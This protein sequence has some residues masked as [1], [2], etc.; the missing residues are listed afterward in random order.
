MSEE[1][2]EMSAYSFNSFFLFFF[3]LTQ[4]LYLENYFLPTP[5]TAA[6]PER[7]SRHNKVLQHHPLRYFSR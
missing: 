3:F 5:T 6:S 7:G 1:E 4:R 2:S